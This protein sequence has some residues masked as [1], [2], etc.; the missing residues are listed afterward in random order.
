MRIKT[1]ED[2][3]NDAYRGN[4]STMLRRL[5]RQQKFLEGQLQII[6]DEIAIVKAMS[7]IYEGSK[8]ERS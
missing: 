1:P 6:K 5:E 7:D 2:V 4:F 8:D 3:R